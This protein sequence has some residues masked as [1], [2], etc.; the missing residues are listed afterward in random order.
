MAAPACRP[1]KNLC[2]HRD[3]GVDVSECGDQKNKFSDVPD[4]V[5]WYIIRFLDTS[6]QITAADV[7]QRFRTAVSQSRQSFSME[8]YPSHKCP[9]HADRTII[10]FSNLRQLDLSH[11]SCQSFMRTNAAIGKFGSSLA[12][13]CPLIH[14]FRLTGQR[15]ARLFRVYV[16]SLAL[17]SNVQRLELDIQRAAIGCAQSLISVTKFLSLTHLSL[18]T[19]RVIRRSS[20]TR[21]VLSELFS[22]LLPGVSYLTLYFMRTDQDLVSDA[23]RHTSG[24]MFFSANHVT[25]EDMLTLSL[26]NPE[27]R[28][29]VAPVVAEAFRHL[30]LFRRLNR[31]SV[32]ILPDDDMDLETQAEHVFGQEPLQSQLKVLSIG[33]YLSADPVPIISRLKNLEVL[34]VDRHIPLTHAAD[35]YVIKSMPRLLRLIVRC[36]YT[37]PAVWPAAEEQEKSVKEIISTFP[38]L[39]KIRYKNGEIRVKDNFMFWQMQ[40]AAPDP[41][42]FFAPDATSL[43]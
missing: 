30:P 40:S 10:R 29:L 3:H 27:M 35:D 2:M 23:T 38:S 43:E 41:D 34:I 36:D 15:G 32:Q 19:G 1:L 39:E 21:V 11:A 7:C 26:R 37:M 9:E 28:T 42:S 12:A 25:S 17:K 33:G 8:M 24:L 4:E 20:R 16:Q 5:V 18:T 31:L 14:T 22:Q 13:G 6:S